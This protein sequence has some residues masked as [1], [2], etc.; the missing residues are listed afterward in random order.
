MLLPPWLSFLQNSR[1]S[2]IPSS[3]I[4]MHMSYSEACQW[5][6]LDPN[7]NNIL[8]ESI[9][10]IAFRKAAMKEHPDKSTCPNATERFQAVTHAH[11]YL[12]KC[13]MARRG[14]A[15]HEDYS[16]QE[17]NDDD[18]LYD[19]EEAYYK[20]L[21]ARIF[22]FFGPGGTSMRF[23]FGGGGSSSPNEDDQYE[24]YMERLHQKNRERKA[25][26]QR[27][28]RER[29]ET[30]R[31]QRQHAMEEGRDFFEAWGV[32]QL[33][34]EATKRGIR[35]IQGLQQQSLAELLIEDETKKRLRRELKER[36]PLV[37]EWCQVVGLETQQ[38]WNGR[39]V[40]VTDFYDGTSYI[41]ICTF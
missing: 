9:L 31:R 7:P 17:E 34:Q 1:S 16:F 8:D 32:K 21:Y 40:N 36:A 5:L 39:K 20:D 25:E 10:K 11:E 18:D 2:F 38:C 28:I 23:S 22:V 26:R 27:K 33:Q 14:G 29:E 37:E 15:N 3:V 19:E 30:L 13:V 12:V 35:N 41:L 24:E 6:N 4:I